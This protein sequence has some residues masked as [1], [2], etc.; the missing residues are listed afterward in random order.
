MW[1]EE[2]VDFFQLESRNFPGETE[3]N[4]NKPQ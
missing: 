1:K 4:Y 3:E 2:F